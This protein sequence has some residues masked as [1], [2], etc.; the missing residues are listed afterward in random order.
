MRAVAVVAG[1]VW[2]W[3]SNTWGQLGTGTTGGA[4][5]VPVRVAT[6]LTFRAVSAG[7]GVT[8]GLTVGGEIYCWGTYINSTEQPRPAP[9]KIEAP[10]SFASVRHRASCVSKSPIT[11]PP[12]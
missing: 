4:S 3:G 8:C 6:T 1:G 2:C 10:V 5:T 7:F 12:P 9:T 11:Q